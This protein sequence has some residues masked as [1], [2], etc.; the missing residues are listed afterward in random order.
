VWDKLRKQV[1]VER[2]QLHRLLAVHRPLLEKSAANPPN[3]IE[4]AALAAML[5]SFYNG[6]ENM[7][8]RTSLELG[9][10]LPTS[11]FWHKELLGTMT[12]PTAHRASVLSPELRDRLKEYMEFR[13]VFRHAYIFNF[14]WE[15]MRTL[16]LG[17]EQTLRMLEDELDR[18]LAGGDD[19]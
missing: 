6:V 15:R 16:A 11:E 1:G 10:P 9:D 13:H 17:R 18:F 14:R 8:K 19:Q 4:V 12:R 5:H 3:D 2:E 7:F